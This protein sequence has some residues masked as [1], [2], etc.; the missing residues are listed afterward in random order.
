MKYSLCIDAFFPEIDFYDRMPLAAELGFPAV[1]FWDLMGKDLPRLGRLAAQHN[2]QFSICG[3]NDGWKYNISGPAEVILPNLE[4]SM[5][6]AQEIGCPSL[7]LLTGNGPSDEPAHKEHIVA[8]LQRA[9]ELAERHQITLC[10]EALNTR[11]DHPGYFLNS[12]V[13]GFEILRRVGSPYA[14]LLYDIYHMQIMEGD[15]IRAIQNN[16]AAIGHFHSAAVPG[17]QRR[18]SVGRD[19]FCSAINTTR[20]T[21]IASRSGLWPWANQK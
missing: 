8:N 11:Y 13:T 16:V 10:L 19:R 20:S 18:H 6:L 7:I 15:I 17:R 9:A 12:S 3:L 14:K 21:K 5:R 1:E 2:L 4:L